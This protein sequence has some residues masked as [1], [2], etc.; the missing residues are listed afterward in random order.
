MVH[1]ENNDNVEM[2]NNY[3]YFGIRVEKIGRKEN[4]IEEHMKLR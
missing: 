3:K 4:E 1:L 2:C